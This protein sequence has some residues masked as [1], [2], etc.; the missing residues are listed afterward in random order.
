MDNDSRSEGWMNLFIYSGLLLLA[1]Y[2]YPW[3]LL[4]AFGGW[5]GYE[6]GYKKGYE[7]GKDEILGNWDRSRRAALEAEMTK[8]ERPP[9]ENE[10]TP[11][12]GG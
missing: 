5:I 8:A 3:L 4:V 9:D 10:K 1:L 2:E 7:K 12:G 11:S 6:E